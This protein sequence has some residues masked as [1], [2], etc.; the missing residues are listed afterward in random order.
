MIVMF[1]LLVLTT[2]AA[3]II[4]TTQTEVQTTGNYKLV[5]QAR[6]VAEAGVQSTLDW[7]GNSYAAPSSFGSYNTTK[8]PV[9][10]TNNPVIL[11]A[12][13]GTNSNYPDATVQTAFNTALNAQSVPGIPGGSYSTYATLQRM[14]GA[15]SISWLA[16]GGSGLPQTWQITSVG[17]ISGI[18]TVNVQLQAT[19]ERVGTPVF[20]YGIAGTGTSCPDVTLTGGT[21]DAW[22]SNGGGT[23][24]GTHQNSGGD[25]ST[26]GNVTL[27]GGSS[28]IYGTIYNSSNINVGSCSANGITNNVGGTPWNG[29]QL[30]SPI[31]YND[32]AVPSPMTPNTNI[33]ANSN[34]CWGAVP[35]GCTVIAGPAVTIAPGTYGNLTSNSDLHLT[36]GTYYFNSRHLNRGSVTLDS[37]PVVINLGGNGVSA[38]GTLFTSNSS[39]T[40]NDGNLPANLQIVSACC[41]TGSPP[42]QMAN[43]PVIQMNSSSSMYAVVYAPNAYVHITG[44]SHFLGAA[45]GQLLKSDSSGGYSYDLALKASLQQ[46]GSF[47]PV[48]FSWNKY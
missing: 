14:T 9:Q 6:Y 39:T 5:T 1:A 32:P 40:I 16:G 42:V 12:M 44:S 4:Y 33:N 31:S 48:S 27:S 29:L 7:L 26:N 22:N 3:A 46:M 15:T 43:P 23:Y 30:I 13:A 36:A 37:Y 11:S 10:Y 35:A 47:V 41:K 8:S 17:S 38:G 2:L 25:V 24:A 19:Y 28:R 21:V 45:V 20:N 34:K 18:R